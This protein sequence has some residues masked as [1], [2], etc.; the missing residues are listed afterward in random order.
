[1]TIGPFQDLMGIRA[2]AHI[3]RGTEFPLHTKEIEG[4]GTQGS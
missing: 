3:A 1:M 4:Y 2:T